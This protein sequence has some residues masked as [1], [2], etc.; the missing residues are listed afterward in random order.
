MVWYYD[1]EMSTIQ[2][3]ALNLP[4]G[5]YR[6]TN[7]PT[8]L[9]AK[10]KDGD[11]VIFF[12]YKHSRLFDTLVSRGVS[13][14]PSAVVT[15]RLRNRSIQ[16]KALDSITSFP[17]KRIYIDSFTGLPKSNDLYPIMKVGDNHQGIGKYK[18]PDCP[19]KMLRN[20]SVVYEEFVENHRG[21]RILII[22]ADIFIIEQ[23]NDTWIKNHHPSDEITYH[24]N[25]QRDEI[26]EWL[27]CAE[28]LVLDASKLLSQYIG[29]NLAGIDY[30]VGDKVIGLLEA[31]DMVGIPDNAHAIDCYNRLILNI[32]EKHINP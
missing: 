25:T 22:D 5:S 20:E 3:L 27:P 32:A 26:I 19:R 30:A 6:S 14:Y 18:F 10:A 15:Y 12:N 16:L 29:G 31:N 11:L 7:N 8:T 28:S 4:H 2:Y 21:I 13:T 9:H 17:L 24:W 23:I 1:I